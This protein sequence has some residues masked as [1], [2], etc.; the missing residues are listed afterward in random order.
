MIKTLQVLMIYVKK[1]AE[2]PRR[3]QSIMPERMQMF[4]KNANF[5]I[6]SAILI[7][8]EIIARFFKLW[9]ATT[10]VHTKKATNKAKLKS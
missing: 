2:S 9:S 3:I 7:E 5:C 4:D 8:K 1:A 10:V 6:Q